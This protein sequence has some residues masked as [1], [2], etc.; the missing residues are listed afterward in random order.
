MNTIM[1]FKLI[2]KDTTGLSDSALVKV[3]VMPAAARHCPESFLIHL[4]EENS[5]Y[6][7][8]QCPN[9]VRYILATTKITP[10]I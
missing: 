1:Y 9:T 4:L 2:V 7:V 10:F 8:W 5:N 3:S 6:L